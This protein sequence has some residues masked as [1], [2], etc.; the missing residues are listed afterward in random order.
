MLPV[1]ETM[2]RVQLL[3]AASFLFPMFAAA[4]D[5]KIGAALPLT[6]VG[7][8]GGVPMMEGMRLAAEKLPPGR[9]DLVFE[10]DLSV[11]S[12][13]TTRV[14][15]K[16]AEIDNAQVIVN[17]IVNTVTAIAPY[18]RQKEI[19]CLVLWD[20]NQ[21]IAGLGEYVF[22]FGYST[23]AAGE[24][25]AKYAATDLRLRKVAILGVHDEWSEIIG[26][27]FE[28]QF[29]ALGGAVVFR[30]EVS[31]EE[32]DLRA[33]VLRLRKSGADGFYGPLFGPPFLAFVRQSR[34]LGFFGQLL[35]GD[36]FGEDEIRQLGKAADGMVFTQM[37]S[38]DEAF[39]AELRARF[40]HGSGGVNGAFSTLGYQVVEYLDG[41]CQE[42]R[43]QGEACH[44][45]NLRRAIAEYHLRGRFGDV[46]LDRA[47]SS[48]R[49][50]SLLVIRNG[51]MEALH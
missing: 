43:K 13:A 38:T 25:L 11:N 41:A 6:G 14:V 28:E 9:L 5:L 40:G 2:R 20:S 12:A 22:G 8:Y 34:E 4:A 39:E 31:A 3:F 49:R 24:D 42:L 17:S 30:E 33:I 50:E 15:K 29:T 36:A 21:R 48:G 35:S 44:G 27:S 47:R 18:L 45:A 26:R 1:R 37:W 46:S 10:D 16:M 23:E 7:A 32:S 51:K 19:P